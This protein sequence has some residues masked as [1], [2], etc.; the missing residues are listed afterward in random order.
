VLEQG[1]ETYTREHTARPY[2]E[3]RALL[4]PPI[5]GWAALALL[6]RYWAV[7]VV[8]ALGVAIL[9][10]WQMGRGLSVAPHGLCRVWATVVSQRGKVL[11]CGT[12]GAVPPLALFRQHGFE[13]WG[14]DASTEQLDRAGQFCEQRDVV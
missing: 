11:D 12:G 14:I 2:Q 10:V 6:R 8:L 13:A 4:L 5:V 1:I 7:G 9:V 3:E